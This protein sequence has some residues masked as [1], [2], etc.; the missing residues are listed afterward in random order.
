[1]ADKK[2]KDDKNYKYDLLIK[3]KECGLISEKPEPC[4]KCGCTTFV[5]EREVIEIEE[6]GSDN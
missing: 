5:M 2:K 3:C 4:E 1:M 6:N